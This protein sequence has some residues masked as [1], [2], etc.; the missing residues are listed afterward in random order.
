MENR[1]EGCLGYRFGNPFDG[2]PEFDCEY[3]HSGSVSC[4]DCV[5]GGKGG[6]QDPRV[7]PDER[8]RIVM[9]IKWTGNEGV[10]LSFNKSEP[11]FSQDKVKA[12]VKK[13][14]EGYSVDRS[15]VFEDDEGVYVAVILF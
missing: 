2:E 5:F 3:E 6:T 13:F 15:R 8:E 12:V 4:K 9:E 10:L 7:S 11:G 14:L 1:E